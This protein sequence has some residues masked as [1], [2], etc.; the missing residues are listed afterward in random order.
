MAFDAYIKFQDKGGK[1]IEGEATDEK[2]NKWSEVLSLSWGLSNPATIGPGTGGASTGRPSAS[3]LNI[4][5]RTDKASATLASKLCIG[6][7]LKEV[8]LELCKSTGK[9]EP[10]IKYKLTE[11]Y[12]ESIQWSA[13]S[14]GDDFPTESLSLAFSKIE[15]EYHTQGKDGALAKAGQM[16]YDFTQSKT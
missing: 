14:G 4:M 8:Q 6:E 15:W 3:S 1:D 13:A 7:H 5:K 9:K 16:S 12:V 11:V 10:Y 2:H